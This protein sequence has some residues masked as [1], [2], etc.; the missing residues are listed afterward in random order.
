MDLGI[1]F[2]VTL[3]IDRV[4]QCATNPKIPVR[5]CDRPMSRRSFSAFSSVTWSGG[6]QDSPTSSASPRQL[7]VME[8]FHRD[9][10]RATEL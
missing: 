9:E 7:R 5:V 3:R 4:E 2:H 6:F 8:P 10:L 1:H